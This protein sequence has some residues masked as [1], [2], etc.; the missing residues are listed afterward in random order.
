MSIRRLAQQRVGNQ[1][2]VL[3]EDWEIH[4]LD[5]ML[6]MTAAMGPLCQT[7]QGLSPGHQSRLNSLKYVVAGPVWHVTF[8]RLWESTLNHSQGG[9]FPL[10]LYAYFHHFQFNLIIISILFYMSFDFLFPINYLI[11][12]KVQ[13]MS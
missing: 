5:Q 3:C 9:L 4:S 6:I 12:Y 8:I 13:A 7:E 11:Y 1:T 2:W 10:L